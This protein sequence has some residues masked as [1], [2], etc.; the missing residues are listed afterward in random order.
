MRDKKGR[1]VKGNKI[2]LGR[3]RADL[4]GN[5]FRE[6]FVAW[7]KGLPN[8]KA[9]NL[10]QSF[11]NVNN[12][13]ENHWNWQGGKTPETDYARR[14]EKYALWRLSV[15]ER[16]AFTC[17]D[18]GRLGYQLHAHHIKSFAKNKELRY[19][20]NNGITLCRICHINRHKI[21]RIG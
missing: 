8:P 4:I 1:F 18:C 17:Q 13:G 7:N 15:Y 19:D 5:K 10:P 11:K 6:G 12:K 2:N 21:R 14:N 9:L 3:C 20:V 16:D